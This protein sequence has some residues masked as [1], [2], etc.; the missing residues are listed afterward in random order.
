MDFQSACR[1]ERPE[2]KRWEPTRGPERRRRRRRGAVS[3]RGRGRRRVRS[4]R[5]HVG[6]GVPGS[7]GTPQRAPPASSPSPAARLDRRSRRQTRAA[8]TKQKALWY[9]GM[10][11]ARPNPP[12]R[13]QTRWLS[14]VL[15]SDYEAGTREQ[16]HLHCT[17]APIQ[18]RPASHPAV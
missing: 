10:R 3:R 1:P 17:A 8:A 4:R 2:I 15:S 5:G 16:L 11:C 12:G 7:P 13:T 6:Q 9:N 18:R 14:P